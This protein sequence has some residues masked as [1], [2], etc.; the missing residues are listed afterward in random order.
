[1]QTW[2][3]VY[4]FISSTFNDMHAERDYLVKRV[5][6]ELS[7]WC[8]E[9]KL[10]LV[11]IDLRWGV[12]E[13]DSQENKRVVEVCLTNIDRCR[14]LFMCF[15]GQR[16]GWVPE[17][18]D[19][20][21]ATFDAY[22]KLDDYLGS[23]VTE[24]EITHALIDPMLNGS[25]LELQNRERAFFFMRDPG[26]LDDITDQNIRNVYTNEAESNPLLAA[27]HMEEFKEQVR[28][29]GRP[30]FE[31]SATWDARATTP[32]LLAPGKPAGI[33]RGRLT[34]FRCDGRELAEIVIEQMKAA[35]AELYP[36]RTP[37]ETASPL[38]RELDEQTRFLQ[39]AQEGFIERVGDF[40]EI[41][42]Y[43]AGDD[44]RPCT[45]C[46]PAGMG[47]TSFLARLVDRLQNNG[48]RAVIYRFV[49]TSEE[50]VSQGSLLMSLAGE[51]AERFSVQN[52]PASPQKVKEALPT[53]FGKAVESVGKPIVVIIDAVNQLDTALDDLSWIPAAL[54]E[55]VKFIYSFK[56]GE[57]VSDALFRELQDR[58]EVFALQLHGFQDE[59]DRRAIVSQYLSLYLKELDDANIDDIVTSPGADNPLFLKVLLSELRVFGSHE[60]LHDQI[61]A[62]FG[63]T[64]QMAFDG[65]LDRLEHDPGYSSIP[66]RELVTN[67]FGWL[68]HSKNGLE[69]GELAGL[70]EANGLAANGTDASDSVHL[71]LR[72]LR[73][74]LA[75]RDKRQDFFY[76]SFLLA[77]R[78]R[79]SHP[80]HGGKADTEWH[81]DLANY[82]ESLDDASE[83]KTFELAY[84]YA[85]AG[86][87]ADLVALLTS[88]DYLERRIRQSGIQEL[89][90]DYALADL[91][92]ARIPTDDC[93]QL[94][95][96]REAVVM[97][98]PMV[99]RN[100]TQLPIQLFGRLMGFKQPLVKHLLE[101]IDRTLTARR[102]PWLKPLYAFLPQPGSRMERT[103]ATINING[104][105]LYH[106]RKRM[107]L[108]ADED[109]TVKILETS[110]GRVLRSFPLQTR[111]SWTCLCEDAN[112]LAVREMQK[113]YFLDLMTGQTWPAEGVE[114][115][116]GTA[117]DYLDGMLVGTGHVVGVQ[118][119]T[120]FVS[121]VRTGTL[122]HKL[123]Y[124]DGAP[125]SGYVNAFSVSFDQDTGLLVMSL[126][127]AGF[128]ALDPHDG[129]RV[130]RR[131]SNP[132][133][134]PS[135]VSFKENSLLMPCGTRFLITSTA[136]DGLNIYDKHTGQLLAHEQSFG[137]GVHLAVSDDGSTLAYSTPNSA[138]IYSLETFNVTGEIKLVNRHNGITMLAF[139]TDA[140]RLYLG[141]V[142]G[143]IEAWDIATKQLVD[144]L[145][146]SKENP[147]ELHVDMPGNTIL[148]F[149]KNQVVV[150]NRKKHIVRP[151]SPVF[152]LPIS[153]VA[154]SPDGSFLIATTYPEDG[155]IYC[156]DIPSMECR[157]LVA[158]NDSYFAYSN[159]FISPDGQY[160]SVL[161]KLSECQ[162]FSCETGE[163]VGT[164]QAVDA[165]QSGDSDSLRMYAAQFLPAS[166]SLGPRNLTVL[167]YQYG[168]LVMQDLDT[169][170][171]E[172]IIHAFP[173]C[174]ADMRLFD[175][176]SKLMALSSTTVFDPTAGRLKQRTDPAMADGAKVFDLASGECLEHAADWPKLYARSLELDDYPDI[177]QAI[178]DSCETDEKNKYRIHFQPKPIC[179]QDGRLVY[180]H[181]PYYL[182]G[183]KNSWNEHAFIVWD[184]TREKPLC[185]YCSE[186]A[187]GLTGQCFSPDGTLAFALCDS[188]LLAFSLENVLDMPPAPK[189]PRSEKELDDLGLE[190][191]NKGG[192]DNMCE[193]Y[194]V[195]SEL[196][197]RFPMNERHAKNQ[198]LLRKKVKNLLEEMGKA[199]DVEGLQE[200]Y[201][202]CRALVER[203]PDSDSH[204]EL[205]DWC[206][207]QLAFALSRRDDLPSKERS[208]NLYADLASRFPDMDLY[209]DNLRIMRAQVAQRLYVHGIGAG[210]GIPDLHRAFD[211]YSSLADEYP[212]KSDY[213][214]KRDELAEKLRSL[215]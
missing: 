170:G 196:A 127:E 18:G 62:Q 187:T 202:V 71:V 142:D 74:F 112:V 193:S 4:V 88:F 119:N 95:L 64:P 26:Y 134:E 22:P 200:R 118:T 145:E 44:V 20:S 101:D 197:E 115:L 140:T 5:F 155:A 207:S 68:A 13:K 141:R 161:P 183:I 107:T 78:E 59:S 135:P 160:F 212:E 67:L 94:A 147:V 53:L 70:L 172:H 87:G 176:Q 6:P 198:S 125:E 138:R 40:D 99:N 28:A 171:K 109:K 52:V 97:A 113:L 23:S 82:F 3:N 103:Y 80:E 61:N 152:D 114:G 120:V 41:E 178:I 117:F 206:E 194:L 126:E 116:N 35:I 164:M 204:R 168:Y 190:L 129:F 111:P 42:R 130:V 30:T 189:P 63:T 186:D 48:N 146:D 174:L 203:E 133:S 110:T 72:Q 57:P 24:M 213:V 199:F 49:G 17:R 169:P 211:L 98:A 136:Y 47:K 106:D 56:L 191:F 163:H 124:N 46:A 33:E 128:T 58:N 93:A 25:V 43:I 201:D 144:Q 55:N 105:W 122:L 175:G 19:I 29:T 50:S 208:V 83:R 31:Y 100:D 177:V 12:T 150:W 90:Q 32:E 65:L 156:I 215:L 149:H 148:S 123:T 139:S 77:A 75:K 162:I 205:S 45:V 195:Y 132:V 165:L 92:G 121:D 151:D 181:E 16:R 214:A 76:E 173:G 34:D 159:A 2:E 96:I 102:Q 79:Y 180:E 153:S 7:E 167:Y 108:Y 9:R 10:R 192:I 39:F 182:D 210:N 15:L 154:L 89:A 209:R 60:G 157:R 81:R 184:S 27:Y 131:Y 158:S 188:T 11:D 91:P 21:G 104:A 54:P 51:L 1:M 37:A 66:A 36:D 86:R 166:A 137:L 69:P 84:Q 38:Q 85:H 185:W 8:E 143:T 179:W 14:P 73:V